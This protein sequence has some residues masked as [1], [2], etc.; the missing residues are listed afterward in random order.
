[1]E[2]GL[3]RLHSIYSSCFLREKAVFYPRKRR[4]ADSVGFARGKTMFANLLYR[5][6]DVFHKASS[7]SV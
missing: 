3:F 7:R 1:M 4:A 2:R 6:S 5:F